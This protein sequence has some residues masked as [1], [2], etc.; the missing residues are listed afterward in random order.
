MLITQRSTSYENQ[1]FTALDLQQQL[2]LRCPHNNHARR[3]LALQYH[4]D[5]VSGSEAEKQAAAKRFADINNAYEVLSNEEKRQI[6]DRYGEEGVRQMAGKRLTAREFFQGLVVLVILPYPRTASSIRASGGIRASSFN[7][8]TLMRYSA[9]E[10]GGGGGGGMGGG[11]L[12]DFFFGG[13]GGPFGGGQGEEEEQVRKGHDVVV[14]LAATLEQL[15]TGEE[16]NAALY[17][18]L[19]ALL[20]YFHVSNHHASAQMVLPRHRCQH[21]AST[22]IVPPPRPARRRAARGAR[23]GGAAARVRQAQVQVPS[24]DGD[25]AA[26]ARHVPAVHAAGAGGSWVLIIPIEI[27]VVD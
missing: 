4:P 16:G 18:T 10:S 22:H 21:H 25:A 14:D 8:S 27:S 13:G 7:M 5:K 3:K 12:F 1:V 15:Y 2:S 23:Q 24:E 19:I 11:G 20:R 9:G 17:L 6:Y 26:G